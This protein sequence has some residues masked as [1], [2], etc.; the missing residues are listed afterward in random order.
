VTVAFLT[1]LVACI[2]HPGTE[3]P[4]GDVGTLVAI[5]ADS[6][7]APVSANAYLAEDLHVT[8]DVAAIGRAGVWADAKGV[9][10]LG[11]WRPGVY[12]LIVRAIG[13]RQQRSS[14]TLYGGP[15]DTVRVALRQL[16]G[17]TQ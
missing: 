3:I 13:F 4:K 11:G 14:V 5:I 6:I 15:V 9:A 12:T 16:D 8:T 7:G 1:L 2:P 10:H 17:T